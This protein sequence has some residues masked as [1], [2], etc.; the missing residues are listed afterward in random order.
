L[1]TAIFHASQPDVPDPVPAAV[2]ASDD[3]NFS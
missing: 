2:D 1:E 3:G